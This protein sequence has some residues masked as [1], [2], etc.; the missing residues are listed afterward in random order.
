ML[1]A[2]ALWADVQ[3]IRTTAPLVHNI[4]NFVVMNTT[5]NALLALG[6]SPIMAHAAEEMED[7]TAIV[8]ALVLNIGT[9]S[10]PWI[11]SMLLAG[12][13]ARSK[14]VPVVLDPVGAGASRLRTDTAL[15]ILREVRPEI[16]RGNGSEII[17]LTGAAGATKGVDST[18]D[19]DV[20]GGA[21]Q[22]L[23]DRYG[24]VV[25][26]SGATDLITDGTAMLR[27]S[28]G[29]PLLPRVTGMG[30]TA[31]SLIGAFVAVNPSPFAASIHAMAVMDIAAEMAQDKAVGPGTLQ[32]HFLDA[33][34]AMTEQDVLARLPRVVR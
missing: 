26:V 10:R 3:S 21:A 9:L 16:V 31:S 27:L 25:V 19:A 4:T 7:L 18:S 15:A 1:D 14:S 2:K 13:L 28:G 5:A 17:A 12:R 29:S 30:C 24:C 22:A 23:A 6:G 20:A 33:L 11:E 8:Q 34:Y 32:L